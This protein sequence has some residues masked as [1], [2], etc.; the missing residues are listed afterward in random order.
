M[1]PSHLLK[2]K[3]HS[4]EFGDLH[5]AMRHKTAEWPLVSINQR[6]ICNTHSYRW[7]NIKPFW[8]HLDNQGAFPV[9]GWWWNETLKGMHRAQCPGHSKWSICDS[10]SSRS[11]C[12]WQ[13]LQCPSSPLFSLLPRFAHTLSSGPMNYGL[14]PLNATIPASKLS[15]TLLLLFNPSCLNSPLP[16]RLNSSASCFMQCSLV[17]FMSDWLRFFSSMNENAW[18]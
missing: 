3:F 11:Y 12:W 1:A 14:A 2:S 16:P 13:W 17:G 6:G 10:V 18:T 9:E 4:L 5:K 15:L 7:I 8:S